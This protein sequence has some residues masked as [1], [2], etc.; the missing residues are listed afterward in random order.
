VIYVGESVLPPPECTDALS[1]GG[2]RSLKLQGELLFFSEKSRGM[3]LLLLGLVLLTSFAA[4][5]PEA[6]D[7]PRP[8]QRLFLGFWGLVHGLRAVTALPG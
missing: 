5:L 8:S 6:M 1:D 4:G 2:A 7:S 3:E